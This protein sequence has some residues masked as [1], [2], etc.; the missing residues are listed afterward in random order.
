MKTTVLAPTGDSFKVLYQDDKTLQGPIL[1]VSGTLSAAWGMKTDKEKLDA[2][3]EVMNHVL[4]SKDLNS[5]HDQEIVFTTN[6][7]EMDYKL[8]LPAMVKKILQKSKN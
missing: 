5:L 7:T 6:D 8:A 2:I 1:G 4:K 3:T